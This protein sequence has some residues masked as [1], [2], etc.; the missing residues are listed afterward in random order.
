M[1][2]RIFPEALEV[3]I[4]D[5]HAVPVHLSHE[6]LAWLGLI[7]TGDRDGMTPSKVAP[8]RRAMREG[9]RDTPTP[10]ITDEEATRALH[11]GGVAWLPVADGIDVYVV[12][13]HT[14]SVQ[15]E[16]VHLA[17]LGLSYR[18]D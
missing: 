15:L 7:T 5:Y 13:Y 4:W 9:R 16:P 1:E 12:S 3:Q 18:K 8:W 6:D 14:S 10:K 2:F 11:T 17:R